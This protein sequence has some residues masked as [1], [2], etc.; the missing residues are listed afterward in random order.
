MPP[1]PA[2]LKTDETPALWN[3]LLAT[4]HD[5]VGLAFKRQDIIE[6]QRRAD[7]DQAISALVE[8]LK[9]KDAGPAKKGWEFEI[10][11]YAEGGRPKKIR[12]TQL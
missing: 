1:K 2:A 6:H 12:A 5:L 3:R 10:V 9:S 11:E 7:Q 4:V 8:A